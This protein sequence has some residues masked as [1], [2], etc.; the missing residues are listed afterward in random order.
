MLV[1]KHRG[2]DIGT[3]AKSPSTHRVAI[4]DATFC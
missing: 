4:Q 3:E 1:G 2:D